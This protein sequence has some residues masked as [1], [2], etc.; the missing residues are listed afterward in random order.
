MNKE[1]WIEVLDSAYEKALKDY[2]SAAHR[3]PKEYMAQ[4]C[5][6]IFDYLSS[7]IKESDEYEKDRCL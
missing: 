3:T 5:M 4:L 6:H 7:S 1:E 2:Q